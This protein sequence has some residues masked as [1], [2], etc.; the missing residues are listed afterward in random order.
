MFLTVYM[1]KFH[2]K[3]TGQEE[4]LYKG[5]RLCCAN[6]NFSQEDTLGSVSCCLF[7]LLIKKSEPV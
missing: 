5:T 1:A 2:T 3:N 4:A 6:G 7:L